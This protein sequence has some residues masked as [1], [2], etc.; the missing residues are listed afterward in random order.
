[1]VVVTFE[2][3]IFFILS[4]SGKMLQKIRAHDEDIQVTIVAESGTSFCY[5]RDQISK[6]FCSRA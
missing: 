5:G 6:T 3:I 1:M 4:G 2:I